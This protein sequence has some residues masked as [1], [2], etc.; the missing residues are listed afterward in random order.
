MGKYRKIIA[1]VIGMVV[2]ASARYFE[3]KIPGLEQFWTEM[4]L[5]TFTGASVYQI[6]NDPMD[7]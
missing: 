2:Y 1:F 3:L 4:M 5:V 7:G 6:P